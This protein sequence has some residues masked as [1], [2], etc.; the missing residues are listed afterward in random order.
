MESLRKRLEKE[1]NEK[2]KKLQA[3]QKKIAER[4]EKIKSMESDRKAV[5]FLFP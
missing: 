3:E 5:F 2:L 4:L 1:E